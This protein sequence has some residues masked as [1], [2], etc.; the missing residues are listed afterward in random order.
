[1]TE[2]EWLACDEPEGMLRFLRGKASD[3]K[4]RLLA[5]ACCRRIWD[6]HLVPT[7]D[8]GAALAV[9]EG[10]ADG[11]P[12][13]ELRAAHRRVYRHYAAFEDYLNSGHRSA[14]GEALAWG[15]AGLLYTTREA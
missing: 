1:M 3:R 7:A 6:L 11:G 14:V 12:D 2:A 13:R 4:L 5:V 9:A 15:S 8:I 10:C